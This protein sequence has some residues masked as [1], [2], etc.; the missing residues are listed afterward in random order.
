MR[1][2]RVAVAAY[3]IDWL[4]G[5][6]EYEAKLT[7]WCEDAARAGAA[8]LVFPEYGAMELTSLLGMELAADLHGQIAAL[9]SLLPAVDA[10][11]QGL[12]ARLDVH[13]LAAS[14]PARA[15]GRVVNRARL[16]APQGGIG[17]QDKLIMTRFERER[18]QISAG[19]GIQVFDTVLGRMAVTICYDVEFPLLARAACE[20]G[21]EL[22]LV[23]SC[24]DAL[25]G[26]TRVRVG[27]MA[28][29]LEN[30]CYAIHSP[31]VGSA[32]W[33]PA[34]DDNWGAAAVYT[35]ADKDFPPTGIAAMG[36]MNTAGW[37]YAD[38][39]LDLVSAARADGRVLPFQHWPE[40]VT[41]LRQPPTT[42]QLR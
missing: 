41:A 24:T 39:N 27:A 37:V 6:A 11:H 40:Q 21:A 20:A 42:L 25:A 16:F 9:E 34:V 14:I 30:Q 38:I 17:V 7:R 15:D 32:P 22:L 13:I 19:T 8:L 23:P 33:S 12:A 28:R 1:Q 18:W 36:G 2:W 26:Y 29:A 5:W 10:L 4:E 35:P 31:T 3:P